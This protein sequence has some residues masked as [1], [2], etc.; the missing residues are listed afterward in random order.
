MLTGGERQRRAITSPKL[1]ERIF[2]VPVDPFIFEIDI[3]KTNLSVAGRLALQRLRVAER[4]VQ[5]TDRV[6]GRSVMR[7]KRV[8]PNHDVIV[9][10]YFVVLSR[11]EPPSVS[12]IIEASARAR[13]VKLFRPVTNFKGLKLKNKATV[14]KLVKTPAQLKFVKQLKLMPSLFKG[15]K[16]NN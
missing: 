6:T 14:K 4:L 12:R 11:Y 15:L 16:N 13:R 5:T 2:H 7:L 3:E 1:F 9:D 8:R 10:Q